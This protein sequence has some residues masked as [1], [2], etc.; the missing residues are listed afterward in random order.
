MNED[1]ECQGFL[2]KYYPRHEGWR[3]FQKPVGLDLD[4][5]GRGITLFSGFIYSGINLLLIFGERRM[6]LRE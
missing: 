6:L 2:E 1:G 5:P 4:D 3:F